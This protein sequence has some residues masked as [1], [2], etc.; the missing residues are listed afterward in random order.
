MIIVV[1]FLQGRVRVKVSGA[2][3]RQSVI[4][5]LALFYLK[6]PSLVDFPGCIYFLSL[7]HGR[8]RFLIC[9]PLPPS[10]SFYKLS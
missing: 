10:F 9:L 8:I 4:L 6:R 1:L 7:F 2:L 3:V 5:I